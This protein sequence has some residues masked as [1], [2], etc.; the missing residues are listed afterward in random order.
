MPAR[1]GVAGGCRALINFQIFYQSA[2]SVTEI[3][4][5]KTLLFLQESEQFF[6]LTIRGLLSSLQICDTDFNQYVQQMRTY[7]DKFI[8]HL[9]DQNSMQVPKLTIARRSTIYLYDYLLA[10]EA[11]DNT[12]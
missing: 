2:W 6:F 12:F 9:D 5:I 1:S 4:A 7:R 11:E 10:H 8:A 3:V